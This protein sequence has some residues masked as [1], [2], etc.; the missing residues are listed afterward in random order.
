MFFSMFA[1][2]LVQFD[3]PKGPCQCHPDGMTVVACCPGLDDRAEKGVPEKRIQVCWVVQE[4]AM[5]PWIG[6]SV[7]TFMSLRIGTI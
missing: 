6:H 3:A 7:P 4:G 1:Q 5:K 2:C